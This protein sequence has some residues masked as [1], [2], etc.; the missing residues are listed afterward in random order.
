MQTYSLMPI[1]TIRSDEHGMRL[2]LLPTYAC[3]LDGLSGFSH[4]Q[5]LWWFDGCDNPASRAKTA[6]PCPY[7]GAPE[8]LGTFATR[9]PERP[10][11]IALSCCRITQLDEQNG[12]LWLDY[13]D[14]EDGS[15]LLDLKPY[16]PSLDR[17]QHP[18]VPNWCANWPQ[19]VE[20]SAAFDWGSV[21]HF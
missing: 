10:N 9:S 20:Q 8:T 11:P 21:F 2:E 18:D 12:V 15:P 19:S 14:A 16:T 3:A 5:V 13:I 4:L 6:E 17:I 1:G 7:K